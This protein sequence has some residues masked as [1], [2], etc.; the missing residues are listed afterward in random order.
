[1]HKKIGA[2]LLL[3]AFAALLFRYFVSSIFYESSVPIYITMA[4]QMIKNNYTY[5]NVDMLSGFPAHNVYQEQAGLIYLAVLPNWLA[6]HWFQMP[7]WISMSVIQACFTVLGTSVVFFL[8]K[9]LTDS[10]RWGLLGATFYALEPNAIAINTFGSVWVGDS[11]VPILIGLAALFFL[12]GADR[13]S[14]GDNGWFLIGSLSLVPL[15]LSTWL[16]NGGW[17]GFV[18]ILFAGGLVVVYLL[19]GLREAMVSFIALLVMGWIVFAVFSGVVDNATPSFNNLLLMLSQMRPGQSFY[20]LAALGL[21]VYLLTVS[22]TLSRF[23]LKVAS[24]SQQMTFMIVLG[25][26]LVG[27]PFAIY[28][29]RWNTLLVIPISILAGAFVYSIDGEMSGKRQ[30]SM[31]GFIVFCNF[32]FVFFMSYQV[33]ALINSPSFIS[34]LSWIRGNTPQNATFLAHDKEGGYIAAFA[35]RVSYMTSPPVNG[36]HEHAAFLAFLQ[37]EPYNFSYLWKIKP[38]YLIIGNLTMFRYDQ[39]L[40]YKAENWNPPFQS[41]YYLLEA[42]ENVSAYTKS[43]NSINESIK[44]I[45]VYGSNAFLIYRIYYMNRI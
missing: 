13:K 4:A 2:M 10:E 11:F 7:V 12:I 30:I 45:K 25:L 22:A 38:D 17:F 28:D 40:E 21:L 29:A 41:N 19:R 6:S 31:A 18:S 39:G 32:L 3:I 23:P 34:M 1:M 16:W 33:T 14:R 8:T 15:L 43:A 9:R 27:I 44:L 37:A 5:S 42:G 20:E 26:L 35:G 24:R 36:T